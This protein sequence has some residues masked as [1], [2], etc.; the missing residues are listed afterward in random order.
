MSYMNLEAYYQIMFSMHRHHHY[1]MEY[2]EGLVPWER[3][4]YIDMVL[5]AMKEEKE[6]QSG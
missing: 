1:D 3:D 2:L 6:L 4:I 5:A